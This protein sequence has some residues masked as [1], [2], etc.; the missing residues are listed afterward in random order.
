MA[1][2]NVIVEPVLAL[3]QLRLLAEARDSL[4]EARSRTSSLL[5]LQ[6]TDFWGD[7]EGPLAFMDRR[8]NDLRRVMGDVADLVTRVTAVQGIIPQVVA[9]FEEASGQAVQRISA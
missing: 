2:D 6:T 5:D 7:C 8:R 1:T 3:N 4:H 9:Q